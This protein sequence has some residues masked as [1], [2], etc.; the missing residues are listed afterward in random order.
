MAIISVETDENGKR[1]SLLRKGT[2]TRPIMAGML[3]Y[4]LPGFG[5][6]FG[7]YPTMA[8]AQITHFET[9]VP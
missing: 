3:V 5:E 2:V 8:F 7:V 9:S 4:F 1:S 6:E